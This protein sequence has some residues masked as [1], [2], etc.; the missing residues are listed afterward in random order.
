MTTTADPPPPGSQG[1]MLG[2]SAEV[3]RE[4]IIQEVLWEVVVARCY[5]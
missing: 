4:V 1:M 3:G 5:S 2:Y